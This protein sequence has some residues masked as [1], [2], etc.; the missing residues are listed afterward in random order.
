MPVLTCIKN[1]QTH[2]LPITKI[3]K[4]H[5]AENPGKRRCRPSWLP[6]SRRAHKQPPR[7]H[8]S[9]RTTGKT[10]FSAPSYLPGGLRTPV[11]RNS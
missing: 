7:R 3:T 10:N 4:T 9:L 5:L 6:P 11:R 8:F 1:R 2:I